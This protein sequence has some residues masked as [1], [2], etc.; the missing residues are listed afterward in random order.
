MDVPG[1]D[2]DKGL[3]I[4]IH[5]KCQSRLQKIVAF[6]SDLRVRATIVQA[7]ASSVDA[8]PLRRVAT[9]PGRRRGEPVRGVGDPARGDTSADLGLDYGLQMRLLCKGE[10]NRECMT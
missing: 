4:H 9:A 5:W 6:G 8:K 2:A 3:L 7:T 1:G 10:D